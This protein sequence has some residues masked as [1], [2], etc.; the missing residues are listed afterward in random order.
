MTDIRLSFE[1]VEGDPHACGCEA[2]RWHE[3]R[4][5]WVARCGGRYV[6]SF[7]RGRALKHMELVLSCAAEHRAPTAEELY[8]L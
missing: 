1:L 4:M 3:G 5:M 2:S 6:E 7:D 8:A